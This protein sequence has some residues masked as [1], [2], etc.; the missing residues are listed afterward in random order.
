[1][2]LE[3]SD[4][5]INI[6][7]TVAIIGSPTCEIISNGSFEEILLIAIST[8]CFFR[9]SGFSGILELTFESKPKPLRTASAVVVPPGILSPI[10][11][12]S[13]NAANERPMVLP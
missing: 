4:A 6:P 8:V 12:Q 2:T 7:A 5:P 3:I 1:M 13:D 11:R 9:S 10:T